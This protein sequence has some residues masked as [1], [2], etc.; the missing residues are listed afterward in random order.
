[1]IFAIFCCHCIGYPI[2]NDWFVLR[3]SIYWALKYLNYLTGQ[4]IGLML[5]NLSDIFFGKTGGV[6]F[7][8]PKLIPKFNKYFCFSDVHYIQFKFHNNNF[9]IQQQIIKLP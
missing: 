5:L 3:S 6:E 7:A 2:I 4:T 8:F 9:L 1:M